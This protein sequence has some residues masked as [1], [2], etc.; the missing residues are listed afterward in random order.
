MPKIAAVRCWAALLPDSQSPTRPEDFPKAIT[1][2]EE[3][4]DAQNNRSNRGH[5]CRP[6]GFALQGICRNR[7]EGKNSSE[8]SESHNDDVRYELECYGHCNLLGHRDT[9]S[10]YGKQK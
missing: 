3:R 6:D 4:G 9:A 10:D 8:K 5:D 1:T 2:E 7:A